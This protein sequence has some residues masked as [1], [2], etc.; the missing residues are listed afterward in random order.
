MTF[1]QGLQVDLN[2][3]GVEQN[4]C[5]VEPYHWMD[6][7]DFMLLCNRKLVPGLILAGIRQINFLLEDL[8]ILD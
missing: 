6:V 7:P 8:S 3:S 1:N 4:G 2:P 5:V